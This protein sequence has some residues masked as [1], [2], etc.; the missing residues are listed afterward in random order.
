[1]NSKYKY[2][3]IQRWREVDRQNFG[4]EEKLINI[5]TGNGEMYEKEKQERSRCRNQGKA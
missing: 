3:S 4:L 1:M 5:Q 2:S